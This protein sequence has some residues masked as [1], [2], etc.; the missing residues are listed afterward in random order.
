VRDGLLEDQ[1]SAPLVTADGG[2]YGG[3]PSLK[4]DD[5]SLWS[6]SLG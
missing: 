3:V 5:D 1:L 6:N 4:S 2:T